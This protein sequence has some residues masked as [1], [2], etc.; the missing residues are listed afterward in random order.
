MTATSE[1]T[2]LDQVDHGRC[3]SW[4]FL[5]DYCVTCALCAGSC[6]A[7]GIDEFD[8][9][10]LVRMVS[11]G[12]VE[13]L[14]EARWPWIC[15][16]CGKCENVC[17]MEIDIADLVRKIR[18]L[19]DREKVPGILHKG[20]V[21]ALETGNNLRLPREDF[22]FIVEDVA[23]EV[24]E[25]PGFEGFKA[26]IDKKGANLL[27]TIHNKLVNTHT[28]DLKHWWKIFHAAKEDWTVTS[29]NWEGTSWGYFTGDD[30][31]MKVMAG[32]IVEQMSNLEIKNLLW[33]E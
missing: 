11:L 1:I 30:A 28:E 12:L 29:E 4:P 14:V 13:E 25:E 16:L 6:P 2:D 31:A 33:P 10:M 21:A 8:P 20:L 32:R 23:E 15:T 24:A 22:I 19:K 27:T 18:S 17:P 9:R 7:S 3:R 26:P 5:Q